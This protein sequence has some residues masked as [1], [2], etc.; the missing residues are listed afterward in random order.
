MPKAGLV[1]SIALLAATV[2]GCG[3]LTTSTHAQD[4]VPSEPTMINYVDPARVHG[5]NVRTIT[6][7]DAA[8]RHVQAAYPAIDDAPRLTEKLRKTVLGR[9]DH[10]NRVASADSDLPHRE[11]NVDWQLAAVSD[12]VIGVRLRMGESAGA[13][14]SESRTTV[15]YDRTDARVL[16]SA[17]LLKNG[18][19]L[20]DLALLVKT[21]LAGR[22]PEVNSSVIKA[23]AGF[24]D[25]MGFNSHGDLVVEFDDQQVGAASLGRVVVAV[26]A[27]EI[28][29]L[30][31]ATGMRAQ[32]AA[33]K[34]ADEPG[35]AV[36]KDFVAK[37]D[38][39]KPP[40]ES[41][42]TGSVDCAKAKCVALTYD[43]GPGPGTERLLDVLG[44]Y[45]ARATFFTVGAN[46]SAKPELLKRMMREGHLVG[47]HT[48]S[49]RDLTA[50]TDSKVVDQLS[51]AQYVI[52]QTIGQ[53]PG[54]MRP[55]Y[56]ESDGRIA[57]IARTLG[58]SVVGWSVDAGDR[59]GGK[60]KDIADR[61][62]AGAKPGAV[63]LMH[64]MDDPTIKA[65]PEILRRLQE[66]GY[67]F[68]TVPELYGSHPMRPGETYD[69]GASGRSSSS[70][71][72]PGGPT[73]L[74]RTPTP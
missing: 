22:R 32:R 14:W 25:S 16:D 18:T 56:G 19:A 55:P 1:G 48:W 9:L 17:G 20:K 24:F 4:R 50:L 11:F 10:F 44:R 27:A 73:A 61:A 6:E 31:S 57:A 63:I 54:L 7:G 39:A 35:S 47:N 30:L 43:D 23:E 38:T 40:A 12:Q 53:V 72:P 71:K 29:R 69:S 46:A 28:E 49:H 67:T 70:E 74:E 8:D 45:R 5:L 64:D 13:G 2:T 41:S 51:R 68:V 37:A 62:V 60:T 52:T 42:Q 66:K 58:L 33:V 59:H 3:V 65:A 21:G 26:P 34:T 15:W 36:W